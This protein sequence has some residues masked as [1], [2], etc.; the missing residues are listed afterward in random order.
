[1]SGAGLTL[2]V[3]YH[4][5]FWQAADGSIWEAEGSFARYIDSLAPYFDRIVLAVPVFD[6]PPASGTRLRARNVQLAALPYFPGPRQFYPRLATIYPRLRAFVASCDVVHLRVPSPAAWFAFRL[7][8]R[9]ERPVFA[10][11]VGDYRALLPHLPY[12]GLKRLLFGAY[13]ALEE[14]AVARIARGSLTFANGAALRIKHQRDNPRIHETRTTTLDAADIGS[15]ADTCQ[16]RPI[17]VL[18][19]SRID[20]RKNLRVLPQAIAMLRGEGVDVTLDIIGPTIGLIG[21]REREA[22]AADAARAGVT[23]YVHLRGALPLAELMAA[24][25]AYDIFVLPTGPG[26]G[27][28]RVLLEAMAA[29]LPIVTT[30]VSGIAGLII[31]R[32]NGL[33]VDSHDARDGA[34]QG[35]PLASAASIAAAV[36][37]LI[38]T[39]A[40]RQAII[41]GGYE[42][43]RAH[44]LDVQAASMM[45]VVA[46]EL[47]LTLTRAPRVA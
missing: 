7:A 25:R 13:V 11:I 33:L 4:M 39:P 1:V 19:V 6:A 24:Y 31:D 26:E 15:R 32:S 47:G 12:T 2:G 35:G 34:S 38:D 40:L 45:A 14:H 18:T 43:A 29:G 8:R 5:P 46:N 16:A 37:M 23:R 41:R 42:T 44:T 27:I 9:I 20:P 3:V 21:E 28:P 10:L 17:R 36:R 30:N 22:I